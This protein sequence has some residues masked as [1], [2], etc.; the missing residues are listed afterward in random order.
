L[1]F[2]QNC[3]VVNRATKQFAARRNHFPLLVQNRRNRTW[4]SMQ[5]INVG[6]SPETV[7]MRIISLVVAFAFVLAGSTV[8]GTLEDA[9][10]G[11]GT[12]SYN[13]SPVAGVAPIMVAAN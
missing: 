13:G 6:R 7:K 9:L 10:P 4:L 1:E 3:F 5:Q 8:A 2:I 11:I 12:F